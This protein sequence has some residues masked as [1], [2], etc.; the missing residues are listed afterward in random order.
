V[1]KPEPHLNPIKSQM[2]N[3]LMS[4]GKVDNVPIRVVL[5]K[6]KVEIPKGTIIN[7]NTL[8]FKNKYIWA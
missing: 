1:R 5:N 2:L 6:F 8:Y 3:E 4:E 7:F